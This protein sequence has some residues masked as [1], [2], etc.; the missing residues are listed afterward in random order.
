MLLRVPQG[1]R[2]YHFALSQTRPAD[3]RV[4][5][6]QHFLLSRRGDGAARK[7]FI[8]YSHIDICGVFE[9]ALNEYI[10]RRGSCP[11]SLSTITSG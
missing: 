11:E 6:P 3:T 5:E 2:T 7:R 4:K 10:N 8:Q 9:Y 1:A